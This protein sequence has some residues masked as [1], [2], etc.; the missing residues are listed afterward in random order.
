[1]FSSID[2]PNA[3]IT[4]IAMGLGDCNG[5]QAYRQVKEIS[6]GSSG[7]VFDVC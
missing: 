6:S 1:V 3:P 5:H 7:T 2:N 4:V